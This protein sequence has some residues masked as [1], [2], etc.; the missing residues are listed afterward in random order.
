MVENWLDTLDCPV[1]RI[2]GTLMIADNVGL[3]I[4][5]L[6]ENHLI[7]NRFQNPIHDSN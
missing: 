4:E 5:K 1:F 7:Y 6:R 2:D 3:L